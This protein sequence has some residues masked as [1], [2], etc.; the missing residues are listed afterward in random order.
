MKKRMELT[1]APSSS[2]ALIPQRSALERLGEQHLLGEDQVGAVVVGELVVVAHR[3]RVEGARDLAVAAEDAARHVDLVHGRVALAG[4]DAVLGRV[5]GGDRARR[6]CRDSDSRVLA[7]LAATAG[8]GLR[9]VGRGHQCVA[10]TTIAVTS[11]LTV[12]SGSSTRQPK[13]INWS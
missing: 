2:L 7:G 1:S 11:A 13:L 10:T 8:G 6:L 3:D 9:V 12:A 5:L 4:R